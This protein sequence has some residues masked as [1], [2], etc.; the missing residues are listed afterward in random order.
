MNK[1]QQ[2]NDIIYIA[3]NWESK[4]SKAKEKLSQILAGTL[5]CVYCKQQKPEQIF[6]VIEDTKTG[7]IF[8]KVHSDLFTVCSLKC[9]MDRGLK[10]QSYYSVV[11]RL[12]NGEV[13]STGFLGQDAMAINEFMGRIKEKK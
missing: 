2:I 12:S 5:E 1:E 3:K 9:L 10:K 6:W 4:P 7:L 8:K 13:L 11:G